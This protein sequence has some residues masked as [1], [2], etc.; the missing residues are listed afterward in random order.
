M[1]KQVLEGELL[2]MDSRHRLD[3]GFQEFFEFGKVYKEPRDSRQKQSFWVEKSG[4]EDGLIFSKFSKGV[5][6]LTLVLVPCMLSSQPVLAKSLVE[7]FK[8]NR[9]RSWGDWSR[10]NFG[11]TV[12][13]FLLD[14][15]F[16]ISLT[17]STGAVGIF[18]GGVLV[19]EK[20]IQKADL[21][22]F[23]YDSVR[24]I[25]EYGLPALGYATEVP[26]FIPI[27]KEMPSLPRVIGEV[28]LD[29]SNID[30]S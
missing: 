7:F 6:L 29:L 17:L 9:T 15:D 8:F 5:L 27:P 24:V 21:P 12:T 30:W 10:E 2:Y 26:T 14:E 25:K 28:K 23:L 3:E 22:R 13:E 11:N 1:K 16:L 4:T 18:V 20:Y 19:Y